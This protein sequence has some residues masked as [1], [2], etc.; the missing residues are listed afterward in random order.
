M[1]R[2]LLPLAI[3][4]AGCT[5]PMAMLTDTEINRIGTIPVTITPPILQY[6]PYPIRVE[7]HECDYDP[8]PVM[9]GGE[10]HR[11]DPA[12]LNP[13]FVAA[14]LDAIAE[15]AEIL[16]VTEPKPYVVPFRENGDTLY[17]RCVGGVESYQSG[18]TIPAGLTYHVIHAVGHDNAGAF[19]CGWIGRWAW[20]GGPPPS[21]GGLYGDVFIDGV[22]D[23]PDTRDDFRRIALHETGHVLTMNRWD[24]GLQLS[25]D[26]TMR[27][28]TDSAAVAV[29]DRMGGTGYMGRKVPADRYHWLGCAAAEDIMSTEAWDPV[30]RITDLTLAILEPGLAG[31]PQGGSV[32]KDTWNRCPEF[33]AS[34]ADASDQAETV[35]SRPDTGPVIFERLR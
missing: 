9:C 30:A 1:K 17:W 16:A 27:W 29:F 12:T 8:W 32:S 33:L 14:T 11:I 26:G 4:L 31:V 13:V 2:L 35:R 6:K 19:A 10:S 34:G 22:L 21:G 18:D 5:D 15:W 3:V 23:R 24:K 28:M 25:Q 20:S 7:W